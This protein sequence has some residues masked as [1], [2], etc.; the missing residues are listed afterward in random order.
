MLD[1]QI[2]QDHVKVQLWD[3]SGD[4]RYEAASHVLSKVSNSCVDLQVP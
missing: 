3:V 4:Q 1:R 2:G